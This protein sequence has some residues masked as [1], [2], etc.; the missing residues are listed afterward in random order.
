MV[1]VLLII[2]GVP[3]Y[4]VGILFIK[5]DVFAARDGQGQILSIYITDAINVNYKMTN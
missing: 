4:T 5:L 3:L 2:Y 1:P